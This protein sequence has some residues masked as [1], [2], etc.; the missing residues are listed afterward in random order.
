MTVSLPKTAEELRLRLG[1]VAHA[2]VL[3]SLCYPRVASL[4]GVA[5][6]HKNN[7]ADF[8]WCGFVLG[9][10][11]RDTTGAAVSSPAFEQMLACEY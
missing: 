8:L 1:L 3:C 11:A 7:Y 6:S 10:Q 5:P 2:L 9:L 4:K